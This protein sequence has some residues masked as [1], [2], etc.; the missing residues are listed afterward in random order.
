MNHQYGQA[1]VASKFQ[2]KLPQIPTCVGESGTRGGVPGAGALVLVWGSEL[3]VEGFHLDFC[4]M[5]ILACW[6]CSS[7]TPAFARFL[8]FCGCQLT[9]LPNPSKTIT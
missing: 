9:Y 8:M 6:A 7:R 4:S 3:L 2:S 5:R 1:G